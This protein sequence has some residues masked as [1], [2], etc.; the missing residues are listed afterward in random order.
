MTKTIAH[1]SLVAL[2]LIWGMSFLVLSDGVKVLA[3]ETLLFWRFLVAAVALLI[4]VF[5]KKARLPW[6]EGFIASIMFS[7]AYY[8]Q[9]K[10]MLYTSPAV[11]AFITGLLVIFTPIV[12]GIT[13][14]KMPDLRV[15]LGSISALFGTYLLVGGEG[16]AKLIGIIL[17]L[18]CAI[19][20]SI[21]LV[22]IGSKKEL[23]PAAFVAVQC[24]FMTVFFASIAGAKGTLVLPSSSLFEVLYLGLL[25]TALGLSIQVKAQKMI[26]PSEASLIFSL[27]PVFATI[28]SALL[29]HDTIT[30]RSFLGMLMIFIASL[31][32]DFNCKWQLKNILPRHESGL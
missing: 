27:E 30:W 17:Q 5:I 2:T 4:I 1:W 11:A 26:S 22:Y 8:S 32:V 14:R 16:S 21:H 9:T 12:E 6:K 7:I 10:G 25:A 19:F 31:A 15:W 20:F 23:D 29:L 18:T 3:P 28:F 24:I 13:Y